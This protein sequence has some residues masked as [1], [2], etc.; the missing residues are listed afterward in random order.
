MI[1]AEAEKAVRQMCREWAKERGI[2]RAD[3]A[4]A[5]FIDFWQW[6]QSNYS[7]YLRFRTTTSVI[8]DVEMWF[9]DEMGQK[10]FN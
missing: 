1:K 10:G 3:F 4:T 9:E 5:S 6:A 8:Y 2:A 7:S